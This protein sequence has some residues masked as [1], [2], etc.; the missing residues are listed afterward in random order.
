MKANYPQALN[1]LAWVLSTARQP[2]RRDGN[3][4][5]KLAEQANQLTSYGNPS[6]LRTLAAAYAETGRFPEAVN[7]ARQAGTLA[8]AQ[9]NHALAGALREDL[10]LYE[11]GKAFPAN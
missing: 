3:Q 10:R 2:T 4:A 1:N 9:S 6:F 5:V 7:T 11:S 8:E